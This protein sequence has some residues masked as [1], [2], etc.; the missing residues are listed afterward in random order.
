MKLAQPCQKEAKSRTNMS[1]CRAGL[2]EIRHLCIGKNRKLL[3]L[4][5]SKSQFAPGSLACQALIDSAKFGVQATE[6][7]AANDNESRNQR[8]IACQIDG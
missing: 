7:P 6:Y 5:V 3:L 2:L 8:M 4:D 1:A